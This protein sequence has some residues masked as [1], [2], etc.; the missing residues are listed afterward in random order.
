MLPGV[1]GEVALGLRVALGVGLDDRQLRRQLCAG[2]DDVRLDA[3]DLPEDA[4]GAV[5][6]RLDVGLPGRGDEQR[7]VA[8]GDETLDPLAH[9][10]AGGEQV[11][12]DVGQP[13][14][15]LLVR[16]VGE[17][18]D[19]GLQ[20]RLGGLVE[21]L[22]VDE[23][24]RDA[25]GAAGDGGVERVDHLV[26]V[27]VLGTGELVAAAQQLAGV[28][29]AVAG[30]HEERVRGHVVDQHELE[31][32]RA[33][34]DAAGGGAALR[35]ARGRLV[36]VAAARGDHRADQAGRA[37]GQRCAP[38]ERGERMR[39]GAS[40]RAS[41]HSR[42]S[43]ASLTGIQFRHCPS[44]SVGPSGAIVIGHIGALSRH[45]VIANE[46]PVCRPRL[47]YPQPQRPLVSATG[48]T[49]GRT[50]GRRR[51][52]VMTDVA[53]LAGVS[54]QTV[55]R[56]LNGS[57]QVRPATRERVLVAM[58]ELD[59]RPNSAARALVTGRSRTLGVVS[60]DTTLYGPASTLYAIERAAHEAGYFITH[61]EPRGARPRLGAERRRAA[62]HAGR[63]RH[64]RH[65]PAGRVAARRS[66]T[67]PRDAPVVA[68]EAGPADALPVVAVDQVAGAAL[69]TRHLLELGHPTVV[70]I[71]GRPDFLEA[72]QRIDGWR[73]TLE[74]AGADVPPVLVGDWSARSGYELGR[75]LVRRGR[76][77]RDL[78]RQR[79]DGA[80]R[81][82]RAAR[83][84]PRDPAAGQ[85]GRVR[86]H[87]RGAV[88]HPAADHGA[89]GLRRDRAQEPAACCWR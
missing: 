21:R 9:R 51:A 63:G 47:G 19:L 38:R 4:E 88:L 33:L 35:L 30:R 89:P 85:R 65:R 11:L 5:D 31:L 25:V 62:P 46:S 50:E 70:H 37:A 18:R 64:P 2:G 26:D 8:R 71:A 44:S 34:E 73:A 67:L 16:V 86:R 48:E 57:P 43:R 45:N 54:H 3:R 55:S 87:P 56:V 68:V 40:S 20:R 7:D 12:A 10:H 52:A 41:C 60:F 32:P 36:A 53:K 42:R 49:S 1:D 82:A 28:L 27:G 74:A 76:P 83:G 72:A 39:S 58:Q 61:H 77:Q 80:G 6:P 15:A 75:R 14:V 69:A 22:L 78:R 17:D 24:D 84:G 66:S 79:P 13:R 23:A 59:Y 81:A 29:G